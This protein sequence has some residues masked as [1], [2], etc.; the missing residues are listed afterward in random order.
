MGAEMASFDG[1]RVASF[2]NRRAEDMARLIERVGFHRHRLFAAHP[3]AGDELGHVRA[4]FDPHRPRHV[5]AAVER[6]V[7]RLP[8]R[9]R[10]RQ[11]GDRRQHQQ[12]A[13]GRFDVQEPHQRSRS[14]PRKSRIVSST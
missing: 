6:P 11:R 12:D 4:R 2:E 8:R 9:V 5:T 7:A 14:S 1:L 10:P 3:E 13:A